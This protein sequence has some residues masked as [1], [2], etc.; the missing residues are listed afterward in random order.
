MTM[1]EFI[2]VPENMLR[3]RVVAAL[4]AAGADEQSAEACARALLHASRLGIDSHGVRLTAHYAAMMRSGRI[5]PRPQRRVRPTGPATAMVDADDGL[6]HPA[7]FGR[8][9]LPAS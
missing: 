2:H 4:A 8:W 1:A 9:S 5:N 3:E 7:A 6:G